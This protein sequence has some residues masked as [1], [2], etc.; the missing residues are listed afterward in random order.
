MI[1]IA[2]IYVL[3][4]LLPTLAHCELRT[5]A[6]EVNNTENNE[7]KVTIYSDVE[8]ENKADLTVDAAVE[9]LKNAKGWG[10]S[11]FVA[12]IVDDR[13][14]LQEYKSLIDAISENA[15]LD[16]IGLEI[17]KKKEMYDRILNYYKINKVKKN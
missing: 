2:L 14:R 5:I 8:S 9:I 1:R 7:I 10:S 12:M 16:L 3:T 17:N 11:V 4:I 15:W 13:L 6:I